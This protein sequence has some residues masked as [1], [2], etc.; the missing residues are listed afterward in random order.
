MSIE[1]MTLATKSAG[2]QTALA[3]HLGCTPQN[4]QRM[5]ATGNVPAKHVIKIEAVTGVSRHSL[6]PDLYPEAPQIMGE[7]MQKKSA[8]AQCVDSA[9]NSSSPPS[10]AP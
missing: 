8:P 6:R 9:V 2:S 3:R 1:A 4:V 10:V 5:C 7:I